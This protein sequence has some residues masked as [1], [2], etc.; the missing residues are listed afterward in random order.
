MDATGVQSSEN[1][2]YSIQSPN[3]VI[4]NHSSLG[5]L[6]YTY[7]QSNDTL[8]GYVFSAGGNI[9]LS[10]YSGI[11]CPFYSH[12]TGV[13][14]R[15]GQIQFIRFNA[16]NTMTLTIGEGVQLYI[17]NTVPFTRVDNNF[18]ENGAY[19]ITYINDNTLTFS[20]D[21]DSNWRN[22]IIFTR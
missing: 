12:L 2:S 6:R 10:S 8:S 5:T 19:R 17:N 3:I 11:V 7:S 21:T 13:T 15:N 4:V 9:V 1:I 22:P 20:S 16:N 14:F 18:V